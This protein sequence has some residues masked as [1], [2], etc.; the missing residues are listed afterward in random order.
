M[1][2]THSS[3]LA[4]DVGAK[5]VGVSVTS[6]AARLPRPLITLLRDDTFF[7]ALENIV[8]VEEVRTIVVGFPRGL[9][10]QHTAQTQAIEDFTVELRQHF[11]L[12]IHYQD[13]AL[14]S[15]HAEAEL[16]ARGRLYDKGDI[17]A[18]AATYILED[19]LSELRQKE[20]QR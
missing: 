3:V 1:P 13:E 7:P 17:D 10:G 11:A 9:H 6:L 16:R 12:P 18:L 2:A 14:T 8:E 4:L 19:F 5:R 20:M 15:K